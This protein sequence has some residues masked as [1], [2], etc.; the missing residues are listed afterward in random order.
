MKNSE[1]FKANERTERAGSDGMKV[2][3]QQKRES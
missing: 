2:E 1:L 3:M